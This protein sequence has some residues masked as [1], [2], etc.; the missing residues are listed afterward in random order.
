MQTEGQLLEERFEWTLK[1]LNAHERIS[2][3][4]GGRREIREGNEVPV[5]VLNRE[6]HAEFESAIEDAGT[7]IDKLR[8]IR[9]KLLEISQ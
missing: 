9:R 8:A 6:S 1:Y 4:L 5:W 2:A 7:A 3:I